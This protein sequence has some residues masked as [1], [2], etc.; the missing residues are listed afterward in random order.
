MGV[1]FSPN[2][3]AIDKISTYS[4]PDP[5]YVEQ[6]RKKLT[7]KEIIAVESRCRKYMDAAGYKT[8][9]TTN[10]MGPAAFTKFFY[11]VDNRVRRIRFNIDRYGFWVWFGYVIFKRLP[12]K[13]FRTYFSTRKNIVDRLHLK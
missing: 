13:K 3:L 9:I 10:E 4:K 11:R 6:W 5:K 7:T 1:G 8:H 12:F 2:M